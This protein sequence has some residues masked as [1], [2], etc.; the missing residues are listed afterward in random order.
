MSRA[1]VSFLSRLLSETSLGFHV[2][3]EG[4]YSTTPESPKLRNKY[5]IKT[6]NQMN[7]ITLLLT[8]QTHPNTAQ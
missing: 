8:G 7:N 4:R 2:S 5:L 6:T 3:E 1:L